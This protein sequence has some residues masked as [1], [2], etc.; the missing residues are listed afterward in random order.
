VQFPEPIKSGEPWVKRYAARV[1][2]KLK[3]IGFLFDR[4][5][6]KYGFE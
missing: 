6:F 3:D 1:V 4:R 2:A 5:V